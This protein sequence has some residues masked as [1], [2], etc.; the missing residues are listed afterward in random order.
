MIPSEANVQGAAEESRAG[1]AVL[2]DAQTIIRHVIRDDL[3]LYKAALLSSGKSRTTVARVLSVLRGTYEQFGKKGLIAWERVR[4]IR[5][6]PLHF[7]GYSITYKQGDFKARTE[8]DEPAE[9]DDKW[10]S[11]VQIGQEAYR[12]L[13]A[14]FVEKAVRTPA[15]A[16]GRELYTVPFEPYARVRSVW[17]CR[18]P[19]CRAVAGRAKTTVRAGR[20]A[21]SAGSTAAALPLSDP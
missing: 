6:L 11:R 2:C 10:H 3:R 14:Y 17:P 19:C 18:S 21:A 16:L 13:K 8:S 4:D 12:D 1:F 5:R 7:A 15:E 9:P 20:A